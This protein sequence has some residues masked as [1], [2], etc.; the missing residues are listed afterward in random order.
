[1]GL[2]FPCSDKLARS[3]YSGRS[4][5]RPLYFYRAQCATGPF[6]TLPSPPLADLRH[7]RST[8]SPT[9]RACRARRRLHPNTIDAKQTEPEPAWMSSPTR[10]QRREESGQMEGQFASKGY[11]ATE[12]ALS[13]RP[14]FN[15]RASGASGASGAPFIGARERA[16]RRG[17]VSRA[18]RAEGGTP[19]SQSTR[20]GGA[21]WRG[22]E[23]VEKQA[24][25]PCPH[26]GSEG[27]I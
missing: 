11:T 14:R 20:G 16:R 9:R 3:T 25:Q 27:A 23:S 26:E 24:R 1:M 18:R 19:S 8:I 12:A 6:E 10:D 4:Q 21:L 2:Y 7:L 17:A 5:R 15:R 13:Q 22:E